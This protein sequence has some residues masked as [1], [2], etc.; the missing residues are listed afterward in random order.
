[1]RQS[2]PEDDRTQYV[3]GSTTAVLIDT[4]LA[5]AISV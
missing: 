3:C 2:I 5:G 4:S 1:M